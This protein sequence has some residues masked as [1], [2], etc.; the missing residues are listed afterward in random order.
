MAW[1][2]RPDGIRIGYDEV[3][4]SVRQWVERTL[5]DS[6]TDVT[7]RVGG[8]SPAAAVTVQTAGGRR[9]FVKAVGATINPD[10]PTLFRHEIRV[11]AALPIVPWRASLLDS[12]DDGEWVGLLLED[13]DGGHPDLDDPAAR[14]VVLDVVQA[15][16]RELL[17]VADPSDQPT[18]GDLAATHWLPMLDEPSPDEAAALPS[19]FRARHGELRALTA[20]GIASFAEDTF[21]SYDVRYDNLLLRADSGQPVIVD[22]GQSRVGPRWTDTMA[23]ALD[24]AE[25]PAFDEMVASFGLDDA[26]ERAV[27]AFLT[28]F[29]ARLT[30][31]STHPAPPGLPYLPEFRRDVGDR[32]L[33]GARRR[34][35]L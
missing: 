14:A 29:G 27:T 10:T 9:V 32:C 17:G 19:W 3:P 4:S 34:L 25:Q 15:Q 13:I 1:R 18:V 8:M 21:C 20:D 6:V 22:W 11:L 31:L 2:G 35:G 24:W 16:S 28:G 26:E 7:P 33:A 12:Y 23:F 30:M 5:G